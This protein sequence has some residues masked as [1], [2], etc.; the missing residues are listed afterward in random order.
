MK[1]AKVSVA[2]GFVIGIIGFLTMILA[3]E[4]SLGKAAFLV[5][6]LLIVAGLISLVFLQQPSGSR[7]TGIRIAAAGF[8]VSTLGGLI[9]FLVPSISSVGDKAI[10]IGAVIMVAGIL[11]HLIAVARSR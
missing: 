9:E 5:G 8:I 3:G 2:I 10:D 1:L 11:F 4:R 7:G 6:F